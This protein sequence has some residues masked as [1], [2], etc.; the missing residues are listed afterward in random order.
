MARPCASPAASRI[1][2]RRCSRSGRPCKRSCAAGGT[3]LTTSDFPS[4]D[5]P[6]GTPPASL[7]A[8]PYRDA[9]R[10]VAP[11]TRPGTVPLPYPRRRSGEPLR[12]RH[13]LSSVPFPLPR[14]IDRERAHAGAR[15]GRATAAPLPTHPDLVSARFARILEYTSEHAP[16]SEQFGTLTR[17]AAP[18]PADLA[19]SHPGGPPRERI[20]HAP[21]RRTLLPRDRPTGRCE[22]HGPR[23]PRGQA[24]ARGRGHSLDGPR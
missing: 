16:T 9:L 2:S 15:P 19:A 14:S 18:A 13:P 5:G 23:L 6:R 22:K 8:A 10:G 1:G 7:S 24:R 4:H 11:R 17:D 21:A 20:P 3:R 12:P